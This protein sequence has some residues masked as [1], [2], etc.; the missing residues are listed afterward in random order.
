MLSAALPPT[1]EEYSED[2]EDS[3]DTT[4]NAHL[5]MSDKAPTYQERLKLEKPHGSQRTYAQAVT[6]PDG[7]TATAQGTWAQLPRLVSADKLPHIFSLFRFRGWKYK[8]AILIFFSPRNSGDS[9]NPYR[10]FVFEIESSTY[11]DEFFRKGFT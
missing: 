2:D 1:A 6:L 4:A 5:S 10:Y 11:C 7:S 8:V 3:L 9:G